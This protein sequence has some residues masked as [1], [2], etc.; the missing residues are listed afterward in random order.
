[1][2]P[3]GLPP[4][5]GDDIKANVPAG[6]IARQVQLAADQAWPWRTPGVATIR[7]AF[8]LA[9]LTDEG[10]TGRDA[11]ADT[12]KPMPASAPSSDCRWIGHS[13][14]NEETW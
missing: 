5:V 9:G 1:M 8:L 7:K 4:G 10:L 14:N 2:A 6:E 12:G 13:L 11:R 3:D